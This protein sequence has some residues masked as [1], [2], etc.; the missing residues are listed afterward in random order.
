M[1]SCLIL[2][3]TETGAYAERGEGEE[4]EEDDDEREP[5]RNEVTRG[6]RDSRQ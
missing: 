5:Q 4:G 3:V 6:K 1:R 2:T